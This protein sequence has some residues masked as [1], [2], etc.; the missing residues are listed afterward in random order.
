MDQEAWKESPRTLR[1]VRFPTR[2]PDDVRKI[3][4]LVVG[5]IQPGRV[6]NERRRERHYFFPYPIPLTPIDDEGRERPDLTIVVL[7]KSV[8]EMG[9]DFYYRE[10][11]PFRRAVAWLPCG[12]GKSIGLP[13]ELNWC[14]FNGFG[15][16][17]NGGRFITRR[18]S[19]ERI[20]A[21]GDSERDTSTITRAAL[22]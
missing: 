9:M 21:I 3:V 17:E 22:V 11:V 20:E 6:H 2:E 4:R 8:S 13:V 1:P 18:A 14:R 5:N 10:A 16:Y 7:G 12:P 15:W 19:T